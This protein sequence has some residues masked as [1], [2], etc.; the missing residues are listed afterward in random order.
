LL[1]V[2]IPAIASVNGGTVESTSLGALV[3]PIP[4][5]DHLQIILS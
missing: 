1:L 4:R 2:G 5:T 3:T